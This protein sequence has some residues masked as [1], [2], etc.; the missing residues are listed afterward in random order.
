MQVTLGSGKN[1]Q[2]IIIPSRA[3]GKQSNILRVELE[4]AID[5][6]KNYLFRPTLLEGRGG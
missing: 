6:L 4:K 5:A 1:R 2:S 3:A